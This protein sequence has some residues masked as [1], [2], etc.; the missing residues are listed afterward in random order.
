MTSEEFAEIWGIYRGFRR[1]RCNNVLP[2]PGWT[3]LNIYGIG[4]EVDQPGQYGGIFQDE[5]GTCL[6]R[7][8]GVFDVEDNVI[9]GLEALRIGLAGCMEGRPNAPK[10][11]VESDNVILVHYV[12]GLPEPNDTAM[13]WLGEIFDML[14]H[15]ACVVCHIYE[16]ANEASRDLALKGE[17]HR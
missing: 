17:C 10:L 15:I 16:E 1:L 13:R 12:N 11:I 7:Y 14:K 3:K 2:P 9:A 6:V 4:R 8:R 5:N